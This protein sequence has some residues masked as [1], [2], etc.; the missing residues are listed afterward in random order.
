MEPITKATPSK[1]D[2]YVFKHKGMTCFHYFWDVRLIHIYID[3]VIYEWEQSLQE[4]NLYIRPPPGV[5]ARAIECIIT[6]DHVSLRMRG[7]EGYF[8]NVRTD[9]VVLLYK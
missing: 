4:V 9:K 5:A 8:L 7:Q 6:K 1:G 3:Q 2:R